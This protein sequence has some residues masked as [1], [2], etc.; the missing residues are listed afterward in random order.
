MAHVT[1][2]PDGG[3]AHER[4]RNGVSSRVDVHASQ[5][6]GARV[7]TLQARMAQETAWH[8]EAQRGVAAVLLT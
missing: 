4:V 3:V 8:G 5:P 2:E 6:S 1:F 7:V